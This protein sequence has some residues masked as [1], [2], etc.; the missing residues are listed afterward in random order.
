MGDTKP[1]G[2]G[3]VTFQFE[4]KTWSLF[5]GINALC[6]LEYQVGDPME[7]RRLMDAKQDDLAAFSTIRAGFWAALRGNHPDIG[8]EDAG[9][10][11]DALSMPK[12]GSLTAQALVA[13]FPKATSDRP[14]KAARSKA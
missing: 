12:A 3:I 11:I 14:Q 9:R 5:F 13:A 10:M 8:L 1:P 4:G 6:D 7:V 2:H